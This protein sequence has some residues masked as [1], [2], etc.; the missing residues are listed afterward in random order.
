LTVGS[1]FAGI[2][3]I[4]LGLEWTG[5]FE[6]V[7][8]VENDPYATRVLEKHW[9]NV[10]R[11]GDVRTFPPE[12]VDEWRCD[13]IAG[14]FPCQDISI[15][16]NGPGLSGQHSGL[17]REMVRTL[18]V[19]R[20]QYAIVENVAAITARGLARVLG[21]LAEIGTDAEWDSLPAAAFGADHLRD[22]TF[23]VADTNGGDFR[24]VMRTE[25]TPPQV[26]KSLW[27]RAR[28]HPSPLLRESDD[29]SRR[30]DR[31]RC[32]GNAVVPQVAQW[33]GERILEAEA[34]D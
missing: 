3:G 13:I 2:G 15:A 27:E 30:V 6:T 34:K 4:E 18:R 9:P 32:L 16:H 1:L 5:G 28:A 31:L 24:G 23:I 7:W 20:P 14:G 12:P 22:R 21:D 19:V 29:V 33:I 11:W 25:G 26:S 17:W 8:Q 10:K